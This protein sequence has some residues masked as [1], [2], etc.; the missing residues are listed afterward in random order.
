MSRTKILISLCV[1]L[2]IS[3]C[4]TKEPKP[5]KQLEQPKERLHVISEPN[6]I[7]ALV[8]KPQKSDIETKLSR[9]ISLQ[10][11][12]RYSEAIELYNSIIRQH[13]DS[14]YR[15]VIESSYINMFECSL[16]SNRDFRLSDV[17]SFLEKFGRDRNSLM[18]LEVLHLLSQARRASIDAKVEKWSS[19]YRGYRLQ[20]WTFKYI[21]DWA[22]H[23]E[24][25]NVRNRLKRY[26]R[27]FK[28]FL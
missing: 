9:A 5:P 16:L 17:K 6:Q 19:E 1:I 2:V 7:Q 14:K 25:S 21:D 22:E 10:D 28:R 18:E 3:G 8:T 26:I 12:R 20:N 23:I 4:S 24:Q 27:V 11:Q 13:G 15:K